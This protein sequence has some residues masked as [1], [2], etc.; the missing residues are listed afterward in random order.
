MWDTTACFQGCVELHGPI[1]FPT[2]FPTTLFFA[3]THVTSFAEVFPRSEC[4][5][6][7]VAVWNSLLFLAEPMRGIPSGQIGPILPPG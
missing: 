6:I 3:E 5:A 4:D 1:Y 2:H 7:I